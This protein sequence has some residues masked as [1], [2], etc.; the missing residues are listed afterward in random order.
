MLRRSD[1]VG[2]AEWLL[3]SGFS[4]SHIPASA[5]TGSAEPQPQGTLHPATADLDE[6][7]GHQLAP[8]TPGVGLGRR[9]TYP[10]SESTGPGLSCWFVVEPPAGIEPATPSLPWIGSQAPC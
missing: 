8:G 6:L 4:D 2:V 9:R 10:D 1:R 3:V 7:N 5:R